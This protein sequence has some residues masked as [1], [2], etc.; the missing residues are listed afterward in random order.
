[1]RTAGVRAAR[2]FR[3]GTRCFRPAWLAGL[4]L[5]T[6]VF[7]LNGLGA[8]TPPTEYELKALFLHRFA[9]SV[10]WPSTVF[11]TSSSPII[12]GVAGEDPFKQDL[13]KGFRGKK[14]LNGHPFVLKRFP[15]GEPLTNCHI[16]FIGDLGQKTLA[17]TL[18]SLR[19]ASILTVGE[20]SHFCEQGGMIQFVEKKVADEKSQFRWEINYGAA[21]R[22]NLKVGMPLLNLATKVWGMPR[23]EGALK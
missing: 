16:L 17:D 23:K 12:I 14:P 8:E 15:A 9:N 1:M 20:S 11:A 5:L 19:G 13:D 21:E 2:G 7:A 6:G 4:W 3:F 10:D 22:A 18:Q